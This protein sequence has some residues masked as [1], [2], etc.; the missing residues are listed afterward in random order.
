MTLNIF[1]QRYPGVIPSQ[2]ESGY[3][4]IQVNREHAPRLF[5]V[6]LRLS[7]PI[8]LLSLLKNVNILKSD[9]LLNQSSFTPVAIYLIPMESPMYKQYMRL[10]MLM[11]LTIENNNPA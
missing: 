10:S 8:F 11:K 3:N 9:S 4:M 1:A 5:K 6:F 7:L 2:G